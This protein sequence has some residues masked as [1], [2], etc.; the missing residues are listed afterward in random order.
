MHAA[1]DRGVGGSNPPMPVRLHRDASRRKKKVKWYI[2]WALALIGSVAAHEV[3]VLDKDTI[4]SDFGVKGINVLNSL[5]DPAAF[6]A[7]L[8]GTIVVALGFV[9]LSYVLHTKLSKKLD[10]RF[11]Q[12]RQY[13]HLI[14]RVGLGLSFLWGAY[15]NAIFGP[16]I[17]LESIPGGMLWKPVLVLV[18]LLLIFGVLTRLS[19]LAAL[20]AYI[21]TSSQHG[22]YMVNYLNYLGEIAILLLE[23]G[24]LFSL[25][26]YINWQS[27]IFHPK[28][29]RWFEQVEDFSEQYSFP[30]I[31]IA[32]GI[33]LIWAAISV[34]IMAP[35][36]SLDVLANHGLLTQVGFGALF[37]V[38]AAALIEILLG[39]ILV[40]GIMYRPGMLL[41][42][43]FVSYSVWFFGEAVWPHVILVGLGIGLFL[44]GKDNLCLEDWF[45]NKLLGWTRRWRKSKNPLS[46]AN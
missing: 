41:L 30:I 23:R 46:P 32:F 34:K 20:F 4:V 25:D 11:S 36:L 5:N 27:S 8:Y 43:F 26:K 7:F 9:L 19:A 44:H 2:F 38:F 35:A 16:E 22:W 42:I 14:I 12:M 6:R 45:Y 29:P 1:S 10:E 28:F 17:P 37:V 3:Y 33:A 18:G 31:R 39:L 15:H 21:A 13:A 40:F 24:E